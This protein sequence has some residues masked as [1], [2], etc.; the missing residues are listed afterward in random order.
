MTAVEQ[1]YTEIVKILP[2]HVVVKY[3]VELVNATFKAR[4]EEKNQHMDTWIEAENSGDF[5]ET[6]HYFDNHYKKRYGK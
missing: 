4:E 6:L 2:D 3:G 1:L 5:E